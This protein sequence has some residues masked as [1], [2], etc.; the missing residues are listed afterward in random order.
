[1]TAAAAVEVAVVTLATVMFLAVAAV[2]W[3]RRTERRIERAA[4]EE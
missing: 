4:G 2:V 3:V 1:M